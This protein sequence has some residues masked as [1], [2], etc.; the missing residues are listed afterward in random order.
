MSP[1][2]MRVEWAL[3]LKGIKY[4]FIEL[5]LINKSPLILDSN[6]VYKKIPVLFHNQK[7]ISESLVLLSTLIKFGI[8]NPLLYIWLPRAFVRISHGLRNH[9]GLVRQVVFTK[10]EQQEKE[11][12]KAKEAME[13]LE[14]ELKRQDIFFGGETIGFIDIV[15]GW[16][17]I[18]L[19][20][21]EEACG[22]EIFDSQ[23]CPCI[24]KWMENFT[25]LP[26]IK[27]KVPPRQILVQYFQ[28][29]HQ[30]YTN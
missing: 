9:G 16:I 29:L 27:E 17:S 22:V 19:E 18:W 25:E 20:A 6:P 24:H 12:N 10:G 15:C 28:K 26:V 4:Q 5:D 13:V 3:K 21:I 8:I 23:K 2:S 11:V 7:P 14:E 30:N 1:F